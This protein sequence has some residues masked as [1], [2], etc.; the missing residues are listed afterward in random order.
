MALFAVIVLAIVIL[1]LTNLIN[2]MW[3]GIG[4]ADDFGGAGII[5]TCL[6]LIVLLL[7]F[8][9]IIIWGATFIK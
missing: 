5:A 3:R 6:Y 9:Y 2:W 1:V 7:G 4:K 8:K